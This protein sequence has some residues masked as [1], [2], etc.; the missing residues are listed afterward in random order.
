LPFA[1]VIS[2]A[3]DSSAA[4]GAK[5]VPA[6]IAAAITVFLNLPIFSCLFFWLFC[7]G[8]D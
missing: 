7:F 2:C 1:S 4:T 8:F 3:I 5:Q 6:A